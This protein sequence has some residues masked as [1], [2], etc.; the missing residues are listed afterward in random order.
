MAIWLIRAGKSGEYESKFLDEGKVY[1]TWDYLK[2]D[3]SG[4]SDRQKLLKELLQTYPD[5]K[6]R[7]VMNWRSQIHAFAHRVKKGDWVVLPSKFKSAIHIGKVTGDYVYDS[8]AGNPYYHCK[9]V[10]WFGMDIP[11]SNFDQDILYSFGAFM[12]VCQIKRNNAEERIKRMSKNNWQVKTSDVVA[13]GAT[14]GDVDDTR[15]SS[16]CNE[17]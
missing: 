11:R 9:T 14:D 10:D 8:K 12:T 17:I 3:L 2:I 6:K 16:F 13:P 4:F 15:C 1:L 7:T 5:A